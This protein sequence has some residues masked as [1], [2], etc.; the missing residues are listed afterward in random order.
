V[1]C[2]L[3][4]KNFLAQ[5]FYGAA[6]IGAQRFLQSDVQELHAFEL[7]GTAQRAAINGTHAAIFDQLCH[8]GFRLGVIS[9]DE[10]IQGLTGDLPGHQGAGEGGIEG[11]DHVGV[12]RYDFAELFCRG[13]IWRGSQTVKG[14]QRVGY[15]DD[16]F[17][18]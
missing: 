1:S 18:G 2:T 12:M 6:V 7:A 4:Q 13:R 16:N 11:F 10:N 3:E 17:S 5:D 9:S 8:L 15:V 14:G